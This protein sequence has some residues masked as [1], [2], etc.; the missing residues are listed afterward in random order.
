MFLELADQPIAR[1]LRVAQ[2][3]GSVWVEEDWVVDSRV[4]D[5]KGALHHDHLHTGLVRI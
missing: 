5:A 2:K 4:S 1:L 3:H